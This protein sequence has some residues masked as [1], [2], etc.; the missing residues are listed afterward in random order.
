MMCASIPYHYYI[1]EIN[2]SATALLVD[3]IV[4]P[5]FGSKQSIIQEDVGGQTQ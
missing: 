3:L 2:F 1:D 4:E 5:Q